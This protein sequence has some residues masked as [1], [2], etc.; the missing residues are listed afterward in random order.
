MPDLDDDADVS[1]AMVSRTSRQLVTPYTFV[2]RHLRR[3]AVECT[4]RMNFLNG[5][6]LVCLG[7]A[8]VSG[9]SWR[10]V[11]SAG[12]A[13]PRCDTERLSGR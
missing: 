1:R 5:A 10:S 3:L 12:D 6:L 8:S 11:S 9:Y 2:S 7:L 13:F 4:V